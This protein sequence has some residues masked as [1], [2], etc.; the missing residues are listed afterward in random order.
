MNTT[1]FSIEKALGAITRRPAFSA[2]NPHPRE[3]S[4]ELQVNWR[5]L[6]NHSDWRHAKVTTTLDLYSQS[7]DASKLSAQK[8]MAMAITRAAVAAD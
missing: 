2:N 3:L 4:E 6:S 5:G 8:E 7:I 1:R